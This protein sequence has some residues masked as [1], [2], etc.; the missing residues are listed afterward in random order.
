MIPV[1][2]Y[3]NGR[4][5][6]LHQGNDLGQAPAVPDRRLGPEGVAQSRPRNGV[7]YQRR[8]DH[9]R[10]HRWVTPCI[11]TSHGVTVEARAVTQV[12]DNPKPL[13]LG[14]RRVLRVLSTFVPVAALAACVSPTA[15]SSAA[16]S[17]PAGK[18]PYATCE[19]RDLINPL[20]D[21]IN[22]LGDLIN[23]L[24]SVAVKPGA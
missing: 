1:I 21:L 12:A 7:P 3:H 24:G 13:E 14:M 15:P 11:T 19:N 10:L 6:G 17:C 22:P 20:G 16:T 18:V 9:G 8:D 2:G 4:Q 23:P 5:S